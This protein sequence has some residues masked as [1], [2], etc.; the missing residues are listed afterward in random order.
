MLNDLIKG[1]IYEVRSRNL[2]LAVYDGKGGFIGIREKFGDRY[3]FTE[4][5]SRECGGEPTGCDTVR[6]LELVGEVPANVLVEKNEEIFQI[7]DMRKF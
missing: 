3:L 5:L 2:S 1:G 7:L 6:P 4:Y